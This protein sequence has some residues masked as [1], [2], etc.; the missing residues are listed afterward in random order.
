MSSCLLAAGLDPAT[1]VQV[2]QEAVDRIVGWGA[3]SGLE[4]N[5]KK[6]AV[7]M[8]TKKRKLGNFNKIK[9][10]GVEVEYSDST[11][12]LGVELDRQLNFKL[13][14]KQK[15]AK[16]KKLLMG[17]KNSI[18]KLWGP[19]PKM[20]SWAYTSMVRPM[21]AYGAGAWGLKAANFEKELAKIQRLAMLSMTFVYRSTPSKGLEVILGWH[22]LHS[23]VKWQ[24]LR[25]SLR[26]KD[27]FNVKW[28]GIGRGKMRSTNFEWMKQLSKLGWD[29]ILLDKFNFQPCFEISFGIRNVEKKVIT[30]N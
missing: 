22:P 23:L 25:V 9:I 6:T 14:V 4:F 20:I 12:Y 30:G 11:R 24:G 28:D 5:A 8:F 2:S 18:G 16:A 19:S 13:H 15:V 21:V 27:T 3:A 17:L 26:I 1:I 10:N 29:K 7:I